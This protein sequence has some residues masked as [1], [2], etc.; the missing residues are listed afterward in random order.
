MYSVAIEIMRGISGT[1]GIILTVP[2]TSLIMSVLL[3]DKHKEKLYNTP[4]NYQG[5]VKGDL[6]Q[7]QL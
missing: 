5:G 1:M 2:I 7:I 3:T 4:R 6:C